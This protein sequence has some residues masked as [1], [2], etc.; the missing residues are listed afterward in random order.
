MSN[1]IQFKIRNQKPTTK[2]Y[3]WYNNGIE[4]KLTK[5][6]PLNWTLGMI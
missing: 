5:N 3:K 1:I 2:G 4:Q 6:P